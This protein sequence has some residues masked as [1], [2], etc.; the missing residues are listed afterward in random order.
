V[1]NGSADQWHHAYQYDAD[2]RITNAYTNKE[3]PI[4]STGL[5]IALENELLQNSDWQRD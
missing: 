1:Q 3:T 4:L 2:N 5:P